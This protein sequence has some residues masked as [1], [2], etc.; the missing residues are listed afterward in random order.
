MP[1]VDQPSPKQPNPELEHLSRLKNWCE[2]E[3]KTFSG[4]PEKVPEVTR[5]PLRMDPL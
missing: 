2:N 1:N 5:D 4:F 3:E